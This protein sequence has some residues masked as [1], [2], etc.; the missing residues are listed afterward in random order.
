MN[1]T[2]KNLKRSR[3]L[4]EKYPNHLPVIVLTD[5]LKIEKKKYLVSKQ[6]TLGNFMYLLKSKINI[7]KNEGMIF[8]IEKKMPV[9]SDTIE[10]IYKLNSCSDEYLYI[11]VLIENTFG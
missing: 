5:I 9:L 6:S 7:N 8:I 3:Q 1:E 2:N 11:T 4:R 10:E